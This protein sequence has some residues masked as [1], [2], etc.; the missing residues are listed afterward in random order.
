LAV[1]IRL[2]PYTCGIYLFYYC[3]YDYEQADDAGK[4]VL[5]QKQIALRYLRSWFFIDLP[6]SLPWDFILDD[7]GY[8]AAGPQILQLLRMLR[9]VR[10][11]KLA[12]LLK[13]GRIMGKLQEE[14]W[15]NPSSLELSK[16][17]V[18]LMLLVHLSGCIW[19]FVSASSPAEEHTWLKA[20]DVT[21]ILIIISY[22]LT[23]LLLL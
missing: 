17:I 12:R 22:H 13:L 11:L 7:N 19:H 9:L 21:V 20:V 23:T 6:S 16:L 2:I 1:L 5:E 10:L 18:Y 4:L 15:L 8:D 14:G 3:Y